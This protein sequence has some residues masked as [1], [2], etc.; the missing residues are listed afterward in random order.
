MQ[1][2]YSIREIEIRPAGDFKDIFKWSEYVENKKMDIENNQFLVE[3]AK[4]G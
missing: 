1:D 4:K 2:D 3:P